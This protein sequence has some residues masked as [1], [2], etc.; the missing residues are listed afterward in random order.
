MNKNVV[1]TSKNNNVKLMTEQDIINMSIDIRKI[2]DELVR[3]NNSVLNLQKDSC[4]LGNDN[5]SSETKTFQRTVRNRVY[6]LLGSQI[7]PEYVL[8]S[9][10]IWRSVYSDISRRVG[11]NTWKAISMV[12][13]E[14]PGSM[15]RNA[16]DIASTWKPSRKYLDKKIGEMI[17]KRDNGLLSRDRCVALTRFLEDTNNGKSIWFA[18]N[19]R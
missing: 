7:S 10:Y 5:Y 2:K 12:D 3:I 19:K 4:V 6:H 13:H 16:V 11:V 9:P 14:N 8:L 1:A 18:D 17:T 15:Y